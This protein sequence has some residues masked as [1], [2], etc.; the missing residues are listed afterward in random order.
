M[1]RIEADQIGGISYTYEAR[2]LREAK[3]IAW[4]KANDLRFDW[5]TTR[6]VWCDG[7]SDWDKSDSSI[8]GGY[9]ASSSCGDFTFAHVVV[10]KT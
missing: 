3:S 9:D 7:N 4:R 6:P 2:T 5:C 1:Y 8:V 10:Y